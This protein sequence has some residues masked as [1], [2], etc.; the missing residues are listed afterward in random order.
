[1]IKSMPS[2]T[3]TAAPRNFKKSFFIK[4][5]LTFSKLFLKLNPLGLPSSPLKYRCQRARQK[6]LGFRLRHLCGGGGLFYLSLRYFPVRSL[7]KYS[8][9]RNQPTANE[10]IIIIIRSKTRDIAKSIIYFVCCFCFC[11]LSELS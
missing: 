7:P 1:M 4:S 5:E 11:R 8:Q 10:I 6:P 9:C 3:K 2:A